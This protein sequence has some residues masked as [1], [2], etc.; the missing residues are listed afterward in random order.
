VILVGAIVVV[1]GLIAGVASQE[2]PAADPSIGVPPPTVTLA[3]DPPVPA[4]QV[5]PEWQ[6]PAPDP[7][8]RWRSSRAVGRPWSGRLVRGVQLPSEGAH[9]FTWD[10]ARDTSPNRRWRR[11]GTDELVRTL[12]RVL[13]EYAAAHPEAP[14]VGIGDLSR[15]EGGDFG[16]RYGGLGHGSHQNGLDVDVYYP[17]RDGREREARVLKHVDREL[18]Q[19]LVDLF[20]QAG[21]QYVFVG[22]HSGLTGPP[23]VVQSI[24][25]HESHMHVRIRAPRNA[26][27][28]GAASNPD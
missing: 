26:A 13:D 12:L 14:R 6:E 1:G 20:V 19:A 18:A 24:P 10:P 27:A 15:P 4:P 22:F 2:A 28:S 5:G 25:H 21:A 23:D 8:I 3:Q 16:A 7:E 11:W 17:R 9:F